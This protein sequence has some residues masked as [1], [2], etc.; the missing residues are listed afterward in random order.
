MRSSEWLSTGRAAAVVGVSATT[1]RRWAASGRVSCRRTPQGQRRFARGDLE[2]LRSA[3]AAEKQ[4]RATRSLQPAPWLAS[5]EAGQSDLECLVEASLEFGRTLDIDE[6]LPAIARRLR[7]V[8]GAATCDIYSWE[9]GVTRGL[10]SVD[11]DVIDESFRGTIWPTRTYNFG[12]V[13]EPLAEPFE[14]FDAARDTYLSLAERQA[15]LADGFHAGLVL[16]LA[17]AGRPIG[18][19]ILFDRL[20]RHFEHLE[21]LQGL[22]QLAAQALANAHLYEEV[23]RLHLGNLRALTTALN[24]KDYYTLGHAGRVAAYMV[25]LG[26]ELGWREERLVAVQDAAYLHDIGKLAVSDRVLVKPG[27]LSP[28]EWQLIRQHP[29]ISAE[30]VASLFDAELVAGVR[31]HH[32]RFDGGG[33]PD[34]LAGEAISDMAQALCVADCYD[35][36]SSDRPYHAALSYHECLAELRGCAGRQFAPDLVAAFIEALQHQQRR[37]RRAHVL[38]GQAARLIDPAKHVLLRTRADEARPEYQEMVASLRELRDAHPSVRFITSFA[39]IG[40]QC[41]AVLDTG[42]TEAELSHVGDPLMATPPLVRTLAGES[43]RANVLTADE[44]GVWVTGLAPVCDA[45]GAVVAAVT[46]DL[47]AVEAVGRRQ[48]HT[49]LS[50]GLAAMLQAAAVRS[51]R[52]ELEATTDG[53]TGLYNH[54]YLHERLTEELARAGQRKIKLSLVLAGFDE[55]R[56]YNQSF[57]YKAGDAALCA[58]ARIIQALSRQVDLAA[59]YAGDEFAVVLLE[60]DADG[61]AEVAE[62]IRLEVAL[63][64]A[65]QKQPLTVS[66]GVAT[67]PDDA[68]AGDEL[69]DKAAWAMH[70]AKR[71]GRDRV[72]VFSTGLLHSVAVVSA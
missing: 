34:G 30:I 43:L 66:V 3:V 63:A 62:R 68:R 60:A 40:G 27:P 9:K 28:E 72:I 69:L 51:S 37:Q 49:D 35:A 52:A 23:N 48:F 65:A 38:A 11:G 29:A 46:V 2:K 64:C 45:S 8:A 61:A 56:H 4:Q 10:V 41:A 22:A 5:P 33:Y 59:R 31:G 16:P 53:L 1:L 20:P 13:T 42:E 67:Y 24:A 18:E 32:E 25:L 71:S 57:G 6:V 19:V 15:W 39:L 50:P 17:V 44:F 58:L 36:M 70:V 21:L 47:P 55:F 26:R 7:Q 54:R 14:V 12:P